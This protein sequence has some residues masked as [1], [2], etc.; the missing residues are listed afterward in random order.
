MKVQFSHSKSILLSKYSRM[1]GYIANADSNLTALNHAAE[2][3]QPIPPSQISIIVEKIEADINETLP[4]QRFC[5]LSASWP[6]L[7]N[8]WQFKFAASDSRGGMM[9]A[10][11]Y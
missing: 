9:S 4:L 5:G 6:H 10:F 1:K 8:K 2:Y 11:D 7:A 3:Q